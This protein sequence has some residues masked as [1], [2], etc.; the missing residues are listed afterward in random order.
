ML[1]LVALP[2]LEINKYVRSPL[3]LVLVALPPLETYIF[4]L[5]LIVV[6]IALPPL[7]TYRNPPELT[8]VFE[9][10]SPLLIL[11]VVLVLPPQD[12]PVGTGI[13]RSLYSCASAG[14]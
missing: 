2:P 14:Y 12:V 3:M 5:V 7:E 9:A 11:Q 8:V 6:L 4:P 1:V 13:I 10:V